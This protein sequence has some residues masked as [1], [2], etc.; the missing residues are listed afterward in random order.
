MTLDREDP[1]THT[2]I[3]SKLALAVNV[4]SIVVTCIGIAV[5]LFH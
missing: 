2:A 3:L 4:I 1:K 5:A